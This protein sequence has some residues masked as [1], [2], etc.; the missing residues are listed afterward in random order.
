MDLS[1]IVEIAFD[2]QREGVICVDVFKKKLL[3]HGQVVH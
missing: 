1:G 2:G 3:H